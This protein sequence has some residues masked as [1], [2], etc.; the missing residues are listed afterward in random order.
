MARIL[1][2]GKGKNLPDLCFDRIFDYCASRYHRRLSAEEK[3]VTEISIARR[4]EVNEVIYYVFGG[5]P[6]LN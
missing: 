6:C 3:S 4:R 1:T 5:S 2:G